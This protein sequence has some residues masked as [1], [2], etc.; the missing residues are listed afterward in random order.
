MLLLLIAFVA[1]IKSVDSFTGIHKDKSH[2]T[3][4]LYFLSR[5]I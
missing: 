5:S 1:H 4:V 2:A 3:F